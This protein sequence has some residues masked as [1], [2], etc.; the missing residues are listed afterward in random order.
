MDALDGGK[1]E[2]ARPN[3]SHTTKLSFEKTFE[4]MFG[5]KWPFEEE[6]HFDIMDGDPKWPFGEG[7]PFGR[8]VPFAKKKNRKDTP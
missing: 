3:A 6:T 8:E 1:Q 7:G 5:M 4:N 2:K